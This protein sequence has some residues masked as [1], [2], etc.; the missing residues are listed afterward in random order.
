MAQVPREDRDAGKQCGGQED[1]KQKRCEFDPLSLLR[2]KGMQG[3]A[4]CIMAGE[5]HAVEVCKMGLLIIHGTWSRVLK[6][7][8]HAK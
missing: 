4:M 8:C 7:Q 5:F 6:I 2:A 3:N 1:A